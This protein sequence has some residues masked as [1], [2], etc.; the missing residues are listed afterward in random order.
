MMA[1]TPGPWLIQGK[2][3]NDGEAFVIGTSGKVVCYTADTYDEEEDEGVI[4][5][6]DQ[7]NATLIAAAPELLAAL[8]LF[9][10]GAADKR[11]CWCD[12]YTREP[13]AK[14]DNCIAW[15]AIDKAEGRG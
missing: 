10:A 7:A 12:D 15:A 2:S 5:P 11:P 9:A 13:G 6:E 1:H 3:G 14:C 8:K 4:T